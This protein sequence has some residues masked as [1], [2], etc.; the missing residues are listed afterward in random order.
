MPGPLAQFVTQIPFDPLAPEL[1]FSLRLPGVLIA[2]AAVG[3]TYSWSRPLLGV[4]GAFLAAGLVALDPF[5]I[6]LSRV[7]G[8]D[9]LVATLMWLSL[10]AFLRA[11]AGGPLADRKFLLI[12]GGCAG[13]AFLSKYPALFIGAFTAITLLLIYFYRAL[14]SPAPLIPHLLLIRWLT[15]LT[16]WSTT[17]GVLF[18]LLWP[19]MWVDPLGQVTTIISDALRASGGAHQKGSFFLGEPVPDPG[20]LFYPLVA[21]FRTTPL[22]LLGLLLCGWKKPIRAQAAILLAYVILYTLLVT[23]GGKKQDRYLLPVFPALAMLAAM[24]YTQTWTCLKLGRKVGGVLP[25]LLVLSLQAFLILPAYPYYFSYYNPVV[26]GSRAAAKT[27]QVGWGEG[28]DQAAAYL[29]TLPDAESSRVVS[30]YST[31]FEPYYR[32]QAIY[33]LEEEKISRSAKPGLAANYV[34]IYINQVQRRLPS[35]GALAYFQHN[36]PL[37]TVTLGGQEY[38]WIYPAPAVSRILPGEVRLVGQAE[39]LG[40]DLLD[41]AGRHLDT[42]PSGSVTG[43]HLYWEWQGKARDEPIGASLVDAGGNT[44]GWANLTDSGEAMLNLGPPSHPEEGAIIRSD[45]ALAVFPGTPPGPY[46]LKAWIDRPATGEVVGEF[47]LGQEADILIGRPLIPPKADDFEIQTRRSDS[48][49]PLC[50][51]GYNLAGDLWQP[52]ELRTL[53]LFWGLPLTATGRASSSTSAQLRLIPQSPLIPDRP[54]LL[55]WE[56]PLTPAYPPTQWQPGDI[57]RDVWPLTLPHYLPKGDYSLQ[58]T[59]NGT[60]ALIGQIETGGRERLFQAPPLSFPLTA[61]LGDNS[62]KLLGYALEPPTPASNSLSLTLYWQAA[63]RPPADYTVFVQLLNANNQLIAQQDSQPQAGTAPTGSWFPGE[64]VPDNYTLPLPS[65]AAA[66]PAP[67]RLIVGMYHPD[68]GERLPILTPTTD[69]QTDALL[70]TLVDSL[71]ISP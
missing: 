7:L 42:V 55:T 14:R 52:G 51:L 54:D 68:T 63:A 26:G 50:L 46:Y 40:F 11:I 48:F 32:G 37:H 12:S 69:R 67:Y 70:L 29:N 65:P 3:L 36:A 8:H 33:K 2:V 18:V 39:L 27:F 16:L 57:F 34:V 62:I 53:E 45:Y 5:Q 21:L 61:T 25:A 17:A 19:A 47:P 44:W 10:L 4:W 66:G 60:S 64:I 35:A 71:L 15:D 30:W 59:L 31:T 56:R 41:N 28:L 22:I 24:G 20:P 6:A 38:A 13:L 58:L 9:A 43:L 49:S 1:L 23:Y